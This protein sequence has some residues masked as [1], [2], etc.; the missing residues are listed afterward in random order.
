MHLKGLSDAFRA[1][2]IVSAICI[3]PVVLARAGILKGKKATVFPDSEG[4]RELKKAGAIYIQ[5][6]VVVDGK[7]VTGDG[8]DAA[9]RSAQEII[10][11]LK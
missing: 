1:E 6:S 8:P 7:V 5:K 9:S 3:S 11:L 2:K 4:I 10:K